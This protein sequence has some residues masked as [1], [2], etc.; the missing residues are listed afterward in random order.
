MHSMGN[1]FYILKEG[2]M[3]YMTADPRAKKR[4]ET[5]MTKCPGQS[6]GELCLLYDCSTPSDCVSSLD[7]SVKLWRFNKTMFW[8]IMALTSMKKDETLRNALNQAFG[9]VGL[10]IPWISRR[11]PGVVV[12]YK[13][14]DG[15]GEFYVI[16]S[17]GKVE[18]T[19]TGRKSIILGPGNTF[20]EEALVLKNT[21]VPQT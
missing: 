11:C 1:Y 10:R 3:D 16:G 19:R 12:M 14:G 18:V 4:M 17:E 6:S 9:V 7:V 13:E 21:S 15:I 20:R 5:R 2:S 8:Q